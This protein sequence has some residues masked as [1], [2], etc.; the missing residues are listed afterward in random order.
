MVTKS[1]S[2]NIVFLFHFKSQKSSNQLF[3]YIETIK[4]KTKIERTL[5]VALNAMIAID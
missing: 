5:F 1:E 4:R 3:K 2:W